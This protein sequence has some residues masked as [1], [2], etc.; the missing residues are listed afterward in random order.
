MLQLMVPTIQVFFNHSSFKQVAT[1]RN[2]CS[3]C[4]TSC[5]LCTMVICLNCTAYCDLSLQTKVGFTLKFFCFRCVYDYLRSLDFTCWNGDLFSCVW[6]LW[7]LFWFT[8]CRMYLS[9]YWSKKVQLRSWIR[10]DYPGCRMD[11]RR[12]CC[13]LVEGNSLFDL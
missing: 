4:S 9:A 8:G 3:I 10:A 7:N 13:R 1:N 12:P 6:V 5:T 2:M 11:T